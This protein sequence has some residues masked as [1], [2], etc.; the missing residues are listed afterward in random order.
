MIHLT[1]GHIAE[2]NLGTFPSVIDAKNSAVVFFPEL[3]GSPDS[4]HIEHTLL[5][6]KTTS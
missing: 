4:C 3:K 2:T 5:L 1:E 6:Q